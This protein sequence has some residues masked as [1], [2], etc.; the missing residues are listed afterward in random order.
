MWGYTV[1]GSSREIQSELIR[2]NTNQIFTR[3][4]IIACEADTLIEN[5]HENSMRLQHRQ[6]FVS[7]ARTH[8]CCFMDALFICLLILMKGKCVDGLE[9]TFSCSLEMD[10][11]RVSD[12]N[13][14]EILPSSWL[15][16]VISFPVF[17][18]Q[19]VFSLT[20]SKLYSFIQVPERILAHRFPSPSP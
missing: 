14:I 2:D 10:S 18:I 7:L 20:S 19:A 16:L 11:F 3:H 4:Q 5:M 8:C 15:S 12:C 13:Q 9:M 6:G 1:G 17:N